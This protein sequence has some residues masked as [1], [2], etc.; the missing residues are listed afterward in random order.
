MNL[1]LKVSDDGEYKL[2]VVRIQLLV[3]GLPETCEGRAKSRSGIKATAYA[4]EDLAAKIL[5]EESR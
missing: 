3:G 4:L 1:D 5:K 2:A